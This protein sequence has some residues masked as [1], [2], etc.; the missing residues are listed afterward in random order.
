MAN[1]KGALGNVNDIS[2]LSGE[3]SKVTENLGVAFDTTLVALVMSI[4]ALLVQTLVAQKE[5]RLLADIEDYLTYRLQ[6]RIRSEDE[7]SRLDD[8]MR[9]ALA[10]LIELEEKIHAE[11]GERAQMGMQSMMS[12]QESINN[13]MTLM[14]QMLD[15][16]ADSSAAKLGE[17][18]QRVA[19]QLENI[20]GA[21][22]R[23][24][25]LQTAMQE[26]LEQIAHVQGMTNTMTEVRDVMSKLTP[27]LAKLDRPIPL[28][29][30]LGGMVVAPD[31]R[32]TPPLGGSAGV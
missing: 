14:P 3:L 23:L 7:E 1:L 22:D 19:S 8:V 21:G 32:S 27:I 18:M 2:A 12:A 4:I 29:F 24:A 5:E 15:Q 11:A 28:T 16:A 30:S 13:T 31:S 25:T 9:T 17:S 20:V 26:N 6:S 10:K